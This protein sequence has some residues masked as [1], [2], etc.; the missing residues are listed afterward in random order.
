MPSLELDGKK[1]D[2]INH[3]VT[4]RNNNLVDAGR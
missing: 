3:V 1:K 4:S 2:L